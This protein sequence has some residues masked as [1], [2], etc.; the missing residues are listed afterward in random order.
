MNMRCL[1][2]KKKEPLTNQIVTQESQCFKEVHKYEP[3]IDQ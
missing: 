3:V 2:L 1:S